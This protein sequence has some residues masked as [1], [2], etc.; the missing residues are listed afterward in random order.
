MNDGREE[1]WR[2]S[3][4]RKKPQEDDFLERRHRWQIYI[5]LTIFNPSC[6]FLAPYALHLFQ[7]IIPTHRLL[8]NSPLL[9]VSLSLPMPLVP[10]PRSRDLSMGQAM[11][12]DRKWVKVSLSR[13][14]AV[15]LSSVSLARTPTVAQTLSFKIREPDGSSALHHQGVVLMGVQ[16]K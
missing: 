1:K 13:M 10:G 6:P 15:H 7:T 16:G 4:L 8:R 12:M 2:W 5:V 14:T 3:G 9:V 11:R